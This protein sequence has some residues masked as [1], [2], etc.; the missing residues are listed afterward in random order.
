MRLANRIV[1]GMVAALICL[2]LVAAL[3]SAASVDATWR[4]TEGGLVSFAGYGYGGPQPDAQVRVGT[5]PMVGDNIYNISGIDQTVTTRVGAGGTA[6][7]RVRIENDGTVTD[8]IMV[9]GPPS[10]SEF[11]ITYLVGTTNVTAAVVGAT[12]MTPSLAPGARASLKVVVKAKAGTPAGTLVTA[13]ILVGS[14]QSLNR[15]DMVKVK[16]RRV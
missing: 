7:F 8:R 3:A 14:N 6:T 16:V 1:V 4:T 12:H 11:R 10:N 9:M 2:P 5:R 15:M 13:Q